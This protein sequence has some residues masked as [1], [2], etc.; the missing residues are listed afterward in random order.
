MSNLL[1]TETGLTPHSL[2]TCSYEMSVGYQGTTRKKIFST[3]QRPDWLWG[4]A[5]L[6]NENRAIVRSLVARRE[7]DLSQPSIAKIK[8]SGVITPLA[9]RLPTVT[10]N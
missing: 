4:P 9:K 7:V 1:I 3:L 8:N 2:L 10:I 5:S 6:P